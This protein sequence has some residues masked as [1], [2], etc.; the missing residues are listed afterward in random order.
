MRSRLADPR[1]Q[2]EGIGRPPR[3]DRDR[4]NQT[5]VREST[6]K[7]TVVLCD[8]ASSAEGVTYQGKAP[9]AALHQP[10]LLTRKPVADRRAASSFGDMRQNSQ[11]QNGA[12]YS[13]SPS[14]DGM[15]SKS[16]M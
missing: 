10:P 4:R 15:S 7:V 13:N 14:T 5:A 6:E 1:R 9:A 2:D 11:F 3:Q 16:L 12:T 8:A